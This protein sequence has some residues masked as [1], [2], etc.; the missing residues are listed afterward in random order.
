MRHRTALIAIVGICLVVPVHS[1]AIVSDYFTADQ[2]YEVLRDLRLIDGDHTNRVLRWIRT[3]RVNMAIA[4]L[5]FT[6]DRFPNHPR[7]LLLF[8]TVARVAQVP[9]LPLPY[10]ERALELFPQYALT[11]A[12]YGKYLAE[13]GRVQEG[14]AQLNQAVEIAP[15]FAAT[16]VWL[17]EVYAKNGEVDL[18][19][20]ASQRAR[21]L[22][23][24]GELLVDPEPV[25]KKPAKKQENDPP[26]KLKDQ[27]GHTR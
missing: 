22:G 20:Q 26:I 24:Q 13:I 9:Q 1:W 11:H 19:R 10:Y 23:Y 27:S 21:E 18:A 2:D 6:L 5:K 8:E 15:D 12:Q 4:D 14:L 17:A 16:Y 3:Q 25:K 7:A